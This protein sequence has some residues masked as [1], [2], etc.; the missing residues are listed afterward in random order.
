MTPAALYRGNLGA[1][2]SDRADRTDGVTWHEY[3]TNKS[4]IE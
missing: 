3:G 4:G 1:D 2:R